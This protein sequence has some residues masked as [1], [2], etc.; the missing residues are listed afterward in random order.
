[1]ID[2]SQNFRKQSK[3]LL[4]LLLQT[5]F[6]TFNKRRNDKTAPHVVVVYVVKKEVNG[7]PKNS[8]IQP[9]AGSRPGS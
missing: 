6:S 8:S 5:I 3:F 2:Y 9:A 1:M 7:I 4:V